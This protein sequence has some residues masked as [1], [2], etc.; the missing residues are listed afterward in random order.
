MSVA[1]GSQSAALRGAR[2]RHR[3]HA[4]GP[5]ASRP[6]LSVAS[7]GIWICCHYN[8]VATVPEREVQHAQAK[9]GSIGWTRLLKRVFDIDVQHCPNCGGGG[10]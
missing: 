7:A 1:Q 5:I 6:L 10:R 2:G 3:A 9:L 4:V 8:R